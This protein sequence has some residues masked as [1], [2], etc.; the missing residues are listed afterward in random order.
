MEDRPVAVVTGG[1]KKLG[2]AIAKALNDRGYIVYITSRRDIS[3]LGWIPDWAILLKGDPGV[4]GEAERIIGEVRRRSGRL[5][6]LVANASSYHE[7]PLF[8][9]GDK[10]FKNAIEGCIYP[11]YFTVKAAV[12]LMKERDRSRILIMG[13]AGA[14][15]A[16]AYTR[17]AAHAAAKAAVAV[18]ARSMAKDMRGTGI[19]VAMLSPGMLSEDVTEKRRVVDAAM[20]LIDDDPL[21]FV[22]IDVG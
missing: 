3:D 20:G 9:M 12:P 8:L 1:T 14:C 2:E 15:N 7:G 13:L 10:E 16:K 18:L 21:E 4:E 6:V 11:V 17:I 5:D 22:E 19:R